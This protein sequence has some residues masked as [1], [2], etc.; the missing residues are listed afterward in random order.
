MA[1]LCSPTHGTFGPMDFPS[2]DAMLQ[3]AIQASLMDTP[4]ESQGG[5]RT[6]GTRS[7]DDAD[8]KTPAS[9]AR[10]RPA[11]K[12]GKKKRGGRSS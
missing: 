9:S 10:P 12:A 2:E 8:I 5:D 11:T 1:A 6:V 3:A 7:L 4:S